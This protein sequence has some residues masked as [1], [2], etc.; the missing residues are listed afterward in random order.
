MRASET[1]NFVSG[2]RADT[3]AGDIFAQEGI[4]PHRVSTIS[5]SPISRMMPITGWKVCGATGG[6][7]CSSLELLQSFQRADLYA[8]VT[9][10]IHSLASSSFSKHRH[11]RPIGAADW[12]WL[13]ASLPK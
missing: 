10:S 9:V 12:I 8:A 5:R 7:K 11:F 13:T 2:D 6:W 1:S 4:S 3:D